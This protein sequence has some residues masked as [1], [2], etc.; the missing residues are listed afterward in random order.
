MDLSTLVILV[1][2]ALFF[3]GLIGGLR[4]S[5]KKPTF[6]GSQKKIDEQS[7]SHAEKIE[8]TNKFTN[9]SENDE[10][11]YQNSDVIK[12]FRFC[13]T[14]Q[15]RTPL[16]V[17]IH[18]GETFSGPPSKVPQY[19]TMADG[20]W[21]PETIT[22]RELGI[23]I[24]EMPRE[25]ASDVGPVNPS[26]YMPFLIGFRK[27]VEGNTEVEEK[28]ELI[29]NL[30]NQ[31]DKYRKYCKLI[32]YDFPYSFFKVGGLNDILKSTLN[33]QCETLKI[34]VIEQKLR[35]D[36]V[37][38]FWILE[39]GSKFKKPEEAA[40]AIFE[41]KGY[42]VS[43]CQGGAILTLMHAAC[44]D[45][46]AGKNIFNSRIDACRR[47]FKAQCVIHLDQKD[48]LLKEILNAKENKIRSNLE[49]INHYSLIGT[50]DGDFIIG[51]W[52]VLGNNKLYSI[53]EKLLDNPYQFSSGWPDLILYNGNNVL[54][55]EIK[56]TDKLNRAQIILIRDLLIPLNLNCK[57]LKI[58]SQKKSA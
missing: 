35:R 10:A 44:L 21:I 38:L 23:D 32:D 50:F 8:D 39:N 40:L 16:S 31:N 26:E 58:T 14:Y 57:V 36:V 37:N 47:F 5:P 25:V 22:W 2:V 15:I 7:Y 34:N 45:Y 17:L 51:L 27:I 1:L 41:D 6:L 19:G 9:S 49:E 12:G 43:F 28:I 52:K 24:D 20:I 42:K 4:C 56:T 53:L 11:Y 3:K 29:H 54:F 48:S 33:K 13:A 30:C 55:I 46:L 18:D